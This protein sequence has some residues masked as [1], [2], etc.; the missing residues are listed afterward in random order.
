MEKIIALFNHKGGVSKTTTAFHLG[1][2]LAEAGKRV[3]L[4]D[5]DPQCNLTGLV[6]NFNDPDKFDEFYT[7]SP[8]KNIRSALAPAF[9]ARPQMISTVDP[10]E[11]AG[12]ERLFLLP[13]HLELAEYES[14]LAI[15]QE[16]ANTII[17]FQNIPGA[18][19]YFVRETA[20]KYS[21]DY[22]VVDLN[23][24][25]SA[26]NKNVLMTSDY[27]IVPCSPDAFSLMAVNSLARALPSWADWYSQI[28]RQAH[29]KQS[30]YPLKPGVPK[31]LGITINKFRPLDGRPASA[32]QK[33][34]SQI[35]A[36]TINK[37]VPALLE[38]DMILSEDSCLTC[39]A[40]YRNALIQISDFNSLIGVSQRVRK[41]VFCLTQND[42]M[43]AG[44]VWQKSFEKIGEFR[45][46]FAEFATKVDCL[47]N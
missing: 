5:A 4:V 36:A 26:M 12:A 45:K 32:F 8:G 19:S 39:G 11:V 10:I 47:C 15:A 25:F 35:E 3:L 1:W 24:S 16:L 6:L 18:F 28:Q 33:W 31:F 23:P 38:K 43:Q 21:F 20:K 27:F 14:T 30:S 7:E 13:G 41:P 9:E 2:A 46:L 17:T 40:P 29:I 42:V 34:I 44:T 37:L 22:V